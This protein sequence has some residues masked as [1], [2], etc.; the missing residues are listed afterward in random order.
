[1]I[2]IIVV[3]HT[4]PDVRGF[5]TV[6]FNN[7][8]PI[9]RKKMEI[10]IVWV[11][12]SNTKISEYK[13]GINE[14]IIKMN[15]YSNA[16]E[17]L[18]KE[19]P[20][21]IYLIAG[22]NTP[23][24]AFSI[25]AK[26]LKI[27]RIGGE[28]GSILFTKRSKMGILAQVKTNRKDRS[29]QLQNFLSLNKFLINTQRKAGWNYFKI[30]RDFCSIFP[31]YFGSGA[32]YSPKFELD[33]HFLDSER[34]LKTCTNL[35]FEKSKLTVTGNSSFDEIFQLLK[36]SKKNN[37]QKNKKNILILTA[38]IYAG[39]RKKTLSQRKLF[40]EGIANAIP[41]DEFNVVV[42]IHP[43]YEQI[44]DYTNILGS[45]NS[46]V[47]VLQNANLAELI[48][49]ADIIISPVTGTS[50][51]TAL[52]ARKPVIIWNVFDVESDVLID[53]G[54]VLQCTDQKMM[55]EQI[56]K[57]ETWI[58]NEEKTKQFFKE[59]LYSSDGKASERIADRILDFL[60]QHKS[61]L[62]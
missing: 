16:F 6:L 34:T 22:L 47:N 14:R 24:Y 35:G 27:F 40:I 31:M 5:T 8:M 54:L 17:I 11:I 37:A 20:D 56:K 50:V 46:S 39:S 7:I 15:D 41:K 49:N 13:C 58:P 53:N 43:V 19:K 32:E 21:L 55:L 45:V 12:H 61:H 30:F 10:E 51:I 36:T 42:K 26:S 62:F 44:E 25:A 1:M 48:L 28:M 2:K 57:A 23:D 59:F 60:K 3:H 52:A 33:M 38:I 18:E 29:S 9:L 4:L